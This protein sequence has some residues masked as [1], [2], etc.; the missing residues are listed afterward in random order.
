MVRAPAPSPGLGAPSLLPVPFPS[1][2]GSPEVPPLQSP[3]RTED[4]QAPSR[5]GLLPLCSL[6]PSLRL[7]VGAGLP[8]PPPQPVGL[9]AATPP[10]PDARLH[11]QGPLS[12]V[13]TRSWALKWQVQDSNS[14]LLSPQSL[15]VLLDASCWLHPRISK[16]ELWG[17]SPMRLYLLMLLRE[18]H[19][20]L[21]P[22]LIQSLLWTEGTKAQSSC[23]LSW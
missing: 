20:Q 7:G 11:L 12:T 23:V 2:R 10:P 3:G 4:G 6:T 14:R 18:F 9:L 13:V 16:S 5:P 22:W 15:L 1:G 17:V 21:R 19:P 8:C